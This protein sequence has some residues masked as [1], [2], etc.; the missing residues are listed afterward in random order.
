MQTESLSRFGHLSGL[1]FQPGWDTN[2]SL[3][4]CDSTT[5]TP[6][7]EKMD[8]GYYSCNMAR[9]YLTSHKHVARNWR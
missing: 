3:L 2:R 7:L 4:G 9:G 1:H 5:E 6:P 8:K